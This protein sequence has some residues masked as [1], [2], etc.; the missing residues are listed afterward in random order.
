MKKVIYIW[1]LDRFRIEGQKLAILLDNKVA[2][3]NSKLYYVNT[4]QI[5]K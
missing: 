4:F 2:H 3:K 5:L 1:P